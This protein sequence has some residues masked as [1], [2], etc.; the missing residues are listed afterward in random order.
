MKTLFLCD[1]DGTISTRDMGYLL[2]NHFSRG[3]WE[4]VDREFTQ[5]R[6]GS[7]EGYARIEKIFKGKREEIIRFVKNHSDID[8]FFPLFFEH[9]QRWGIDLKIVSDGFDFYIETLLDLHHLTRIPYFANRCHFLEGEEKRFDFP[10]S[11]EDCGLCG[12]CKRKV[13]EESRREYDF[14]FF[15]GNGLSDR[16]AAR[17]ADFVFAKG[18]LYAFCTDEQVT[19][20]PYRSFQDILK[21]LPEILRKSRL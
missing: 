3:D 2:L 10:Y 9:C 21:D 7:K 16:C 4:S 17:K 8:P 14:I 13:L 6:I 19:C 11:S 5:G 20:H 12:T 15:V 1:F 18:A